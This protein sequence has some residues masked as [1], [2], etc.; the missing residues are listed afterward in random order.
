MDKASYWFS[1][2]SLLILQGF[3]GLAW[4]QGGLY[5]PR[6]IREAYER[7]TRSRTG[8]PGPAYWQN[9]ASYQIQASV[10]PE[11]GRIEGAMRLVYVHNGPERLGQLCF[12]LYQDLYRRGAQRKVELD[13]RDLHDGTQITD[14]VVNGRPYGPGSLSRDGTSLQVNL[15]QSASP[16]YTLRVSLRWSLSLPQH[17][18][19]RMGRFGPNS[20][21][22]GYWFPQV[23]VRDDLRGWDRLP[24]NGQQEVFQDFADFDVRL[25]L[26]TPFTVWATG[27]LQNPGEVLPPS[28]LEALARAADSDQTLLVAGQQAQLEREALPGPTRT[29][30]FKAQKV[31]DFAFGASSVYHWS[32]R[33][34]VLSSG[35][36]VMA[37]A[38]Y[39]PAQALHFG[40]APQMIAEALAFFTDSMPA[41]E[42]PFPHMTAFCGGPS[43]MEF[44]MMMNNSPR[45]SASATYDVVVHEAAHTY[46]PF[47]MGIDQSRY[48]W[49]DEGWAMF[50]SA[51]LID[52]FTQ[53]PGAELRSAMNQVLGYA[54]T[55]FDAP[56]M[57][58]SAMTLGFEYYIPTYYRSF[59]AYHLLRGL[60]GPELFLE[61]LQ[62][63][64]R[65][66]QGK[67]PTPYDF[68]YTF[69]QVSGRDLS[70]FWKSWF[71]EPGFPDLAL[72]DFRRLDDGQYELVVRKVGSMP[73]PTVLVFYGQDASQELER[74]PLPLDTWA[75]GRASHRLVLSLPARVRGVR[76]AGE[77]RDIELSNDMIPLR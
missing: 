64:I 54:G 9:Q 30:H 29:W 49:M 74:V 73:L 16:G 67:H 24:Y 27:E 18:L 14:L 22:A 26:P 3:P 17:E 72:A 12:N 68:F 51:P 37:H 4:A 77:L 41:V 28:A 11:L 66:W 32:A 75:D 38:A 36:K 63:Y 10:E 31:S 33:A 34:V 48:A 71:F 50:F 43:G 56:M 44:P 47:M 59:V 76:L 23:A 65:R 2:V 39:P 20:L 61:A 8:E 1:I 58:P 7:G 70:W 46:F 60:L 6:E 53:M 19:V 45:G 35:R 13:E 25:T 15:A 21:F 57:L 52:R 5:E 40:K 55:Q 62:T 69:D 42:Y